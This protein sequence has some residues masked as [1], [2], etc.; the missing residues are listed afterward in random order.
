MRH[1][2]SADAGSRGEA[3]VQALRGVSLRVPPAHVLAV[4]GESGCGKSTLAR[5]LSFADAPDSGLLR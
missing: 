4:V 1:Y 5:L 2:R 3:T